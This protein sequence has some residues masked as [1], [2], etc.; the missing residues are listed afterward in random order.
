MPARAA[1]RG[2]WG[3]PSEIFQRRNKI[4]NGSRG[5]TACSASRRDLSRRDRCEPSP[6]GTG[7][8]LASPPGPPVC[9]ELPRLHLEHPPESMG[10][11]VTLAGGCIGH[12]GDGVDD[13]RPPASTVITSNDS[14][15]GLLARSPNARWVGSVAP[16]RLASPGE[17]GWASCPWSPARRP[18]CRT[19]PRPAA[20][21]GDTSDFP[22]LP[23]PAFCIFL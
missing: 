7:R 11:P 15:C 23:P 10:G 18:G 21:V 12:I 4:G 8:H 22:W 5:S 1:R 19:S 2:S 20:L 13:Q 17:D 6:S 14:A 16:L 9:A 3:T